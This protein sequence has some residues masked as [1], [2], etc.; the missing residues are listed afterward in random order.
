MEGGILNRDLRSKRERMKT[1][2]RVV[3]YSISVASTA[4]TEGCTGRS[5]SGGM[6]YWSRQAETKSIK[7]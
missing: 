3:S 6:V 5:N 2:L 4:A 1:G 7:S